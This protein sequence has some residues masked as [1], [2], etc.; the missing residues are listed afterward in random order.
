MGS[1]QAYEDGTRHSQTRRGAVSVSQCSFPFSS[2][3]PEHSL[4]LE[5]FC[6]AEI[7]TLQKQLHGSFVA[8]STPALVQLQN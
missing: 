3:F 7:K 8:I 6:A 2:T 1:L 5:L 4:L